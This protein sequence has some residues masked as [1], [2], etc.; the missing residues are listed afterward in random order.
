[1]RDVELER[2]YKE[3][4]KEIHEKLVAKLS[5]GGDEMTPGSGRNEEGDDFVNTHGTPVPSLS[6][7]GMVKEL[8]TRVSSFDTSAEVCSSVSQRR[9]AGAWRAD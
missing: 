6:I 5:G 2:L 7:W 8:F 4:A 1:M 9:R 3:G